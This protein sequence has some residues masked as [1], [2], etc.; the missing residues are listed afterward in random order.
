MTALPER[1]YRAMPGAYG[2]QLVAA[3]YCGMAAPRYAMQGEWQHGWI[4]PER[5]IHPEFVVGSDG[6]S[7][8]RRKS[9]RF[10]VARQDQVEYLGSLGYRHVHAIGLPIVYLAQA[11]LERVPNSLLVMPAHSLPETREEWDADAYADYIRSIAPR[12]AEI[13]LCVHKS[14]AEKGNWVSAFEDLAIRIVEGADERDHNSLLRMAALF[15]RF[16]FVTSNAHGSH[17]VYASYFGC[18]ASVAGPRPRWKRSQFEN[19][20]FYRNAPEVLDIIEEWNRSDRW[21]ALYPQFRREPWEATPSREWA[22]WQLG[23]QCKKPPRVLRR[24]F[25]WDLGGRVVH[26]GKMTAATLKGGYRFAGAA[27]PLLRNLG[28]PGLV[29]AFQL[30]AAARKQSGLSRIWCGWRRRLTIRN[31]STDVDVFQ[32]HFARREILGIRFDRKAST[33]VDLGA[34]IGVSVEVF[35]QMFPRARIIAV[36]LERRNADLC[37]ANHHA[38]RRVSIVNGAIWPKAGRVS[39]KDVG[40]GEWAYRTEASVGD[41]AA[42]VP[43]LTYRQILEMHD[44]RSIDVLKMDIEGAEA[45]VLESAWQDIFATTAVAIIEV[46]DWIDGVRERVNVVIEQAKKHF[47]L[48]SSRSGEFWVIRNKALTRT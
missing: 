35:R 28:I 20:P 30:K 41:G 15:S 45:E 27:W 1:D 21:N 47:D 48:E 22:A 18:K 8:E 13:C 31:G 7:H 2:D 26:V 14:C 17:L 34:N 5:N 23:E 42:S 4:G 38:D 16:E 39:V 11:A 43:A 29:A 9:A 3:R 6:K 46:H 36:E 24:L 12:F 32:Q 10:F 40:D 44:L 37:K 33:V 19:V 25:G